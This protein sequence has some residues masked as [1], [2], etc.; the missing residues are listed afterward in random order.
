MNFEFQPIE[1]RVEEFLYKYR[2][3]TLMKRRE[4]FIDQRKFKKK[5]LYKHFAIDSAETSKE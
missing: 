2:Y 1:K 5:K 4:N 3:W